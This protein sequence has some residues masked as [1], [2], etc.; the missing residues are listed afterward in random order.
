MAWPHEDVAAPATRPRP[1]PQPFGEWLCARRQRRGLSQRALATRAG[2][3]ASVLSRIESGA[4]QP[5][6][7]VLAALSGALGVSEDKLGLRAGRLPEALVRRIQADPEGFMAW[8][9]GR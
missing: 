1:T 5:T 9:S 8:A 4:R 7:E 3:A 6:S 2:I